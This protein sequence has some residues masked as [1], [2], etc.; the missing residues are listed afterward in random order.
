MRQRRWL[1]ILLLAAGLLFGPISARA[2]A[3]PVD[4]TVTIPEPP[5][6]GSVQVTNAQFRWGLNQEAGSGAFFGG[7]NFLS[8]G[9]AGNSNGSR[10]WTDA[11]NGSLFRATDGAVRV[12][13]PV[14]S[15]YRELAWADRCLNAE[16]APVT[17]TSLTGTGVQA[18][19]DGGTGFVDTAGGSA[20]ISWQGSFTVVF[21]LVAQRSRSHS[22]P[23]W[24]GCGHRDG[25][26][27]R[28]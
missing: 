5:G 13:K 6:T 11:D 24:H 10:L 1:P 19:I 14:G 12:E 26:R 3:E 27:L 23:G 8:A 18:V 22:Q 9:K 17:T 28:Q 2:A 25:R 16:G 20:R 21:L 7:C 4:V 15:T